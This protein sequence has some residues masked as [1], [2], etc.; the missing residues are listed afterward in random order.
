MLKIAKEPESNDLWKFDNIY[1]LVVKHT[2]WRVLAEVS[3]RIALFATPVRQ[4]RTR[5]HQ[6]IRDACHLYNL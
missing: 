3:H 6:E 4:P 5:V 1:G 2:N